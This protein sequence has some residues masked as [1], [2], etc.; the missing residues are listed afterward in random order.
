MKIFVIILIILVLLLI[1]IFLDYQL[2][3][4]KHLRTFQLQTFP[5]R[6]SDINMFD[7]GPELFFDYFSELKAAKKHIHISFY[8]VHDDEI[9]LQFFDILKKKAQEGVEVRLMIDRLGA[10]KVTKNMIKELESA[11]AQ[12]VFSQEIKP[13]YLFYALQVRNHR[14]ITIID[15]KLGYL[16]GFNIGKEYIHLDPKLS[17]WRDYHL[18]FTGE[19]VQDLQSC[20]LHDWQ[21]DAKLHIQEQGTYFPALEKGKYCHEIFPTEGIHLE[22][23]FSRMIQNAKRSIRIGTPYFI[24]GKKAFRD[25]L[26]AVKR[27]VKLEIL[28]PGTSDHPLVQEASYRYLRRIIPLGAKVYQ[29]QKGFYHSKVFMIDDEACDV[30]TANFDKRSFYLNLEINCFSSDKAY[31]EQVLD[32]FKQDKSDSTAVTLNDIK[33]TNPWQ[34]TKEL[35]AASISLFL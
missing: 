33:S 32:V 6:E 23:T 24:P 4:R 2:G 15:G 12:F 9:S 19:G 34:F 3:R 7:S 28:V 31:I 16:G 10:K 1:W 26:D 35:I 11:G 22:E 8:I 18:K 13:P 5:I 20:F 21:R 25:L 30:G 27:G 29:Y 17:P 14:K